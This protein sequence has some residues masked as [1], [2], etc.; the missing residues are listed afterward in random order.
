MSTA[1][2]IMIDF[3]MPAIFVIGI[4]VAIIILAKD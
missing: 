1:N 3:I 2:I 4:V